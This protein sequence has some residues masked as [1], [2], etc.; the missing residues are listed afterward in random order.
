MKNKLF[1]TLVS[2]FASG[3]LLAQQAAQTHETMADTMRANGNIYV[4]VAVLLTILLGLIAYL[5]RI[6]K[7]ITLLEKEN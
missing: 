2:L 5:I 3:I 7:K 4:V 1:L 6:D